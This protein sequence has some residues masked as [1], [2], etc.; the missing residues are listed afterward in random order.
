MFL[1]GSV[2]KMKDIED[3]S[4]TKMAK[5][6]KINHSRY[7]EKLRKPETFTF[8][9]IWQLSELLQIDV[10]L[11]LDIIKNEVRMKSKLTKRKIS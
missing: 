7:I 10:Q 2:S 5:A 11:I 6:L 1:A 9:H 4:P 8:Y 3:L